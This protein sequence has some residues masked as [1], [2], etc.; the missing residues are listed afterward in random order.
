[1]KRT[2]LAQL[3]LQGHSGNLKRALRREQEENAPL[4]EDDLARVVAI[5]KIIDKTI[6]AAAKG[7]TR[8]KKRNPASSILLDLLKA[9]KALLAGRKPLEENDSRMILRELDEFLKEGSKPS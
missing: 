3:E 2:P 1:M 7:A 9:R 6:R 5:D 4:T 8:N